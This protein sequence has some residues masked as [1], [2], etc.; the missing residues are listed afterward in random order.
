MRFSCD[1][2]RGKVEKERQARYGLFKH[3]ELVK[4]FIYVFSYASLF[5]L[6]AFL[7]KV[8]LENLI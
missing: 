3:D 6:D 8:L 2:I 4:F 5:L 1:S 7:A